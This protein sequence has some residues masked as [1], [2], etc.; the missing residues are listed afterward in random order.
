MYKIDGIDDGKFDPLLEV[1]LQ[2]SH[3][4]SSQKSKAIW[5]KILQ[6]VKVASRPGSL[7][8]KAEVLVSLSINTIKDCISEVVTTIDSLLVDHLMPTKKGKSVEASDFK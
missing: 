7:A 1:W 2:K 3:Q 5:I 8:P 4:D 6:V